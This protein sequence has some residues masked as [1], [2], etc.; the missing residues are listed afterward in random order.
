[1]NIKEYRDKYSK[2][3]ARRSLLSE[4]QQKVQQDIA[5]L[6]SREKAI[7][8]TVSYVQQIAKQTQEQVKFQLEDIVNMA[9][10]AVYASKY[11]FSVLI[12]AK[13][14]GTEA[15]L[16]LLNENGDELDPMDS[17]GGGVCDILSFALRIALL[18]ISKNDRILIMDEPFKYISKDV[19]ES[20]ME[21][22]KRISHDLD[23]QI[24]CV[25]HDA[26]L[27]ECSDRVFQVTQ[28]E[29]VS[30]VQTIR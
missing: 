28:K 14:G 7:E 26:E 19:K 6:S 25:T 12:E 29:G 10:N 2:A 3:F 5:T 13:R 8:E 20:A 24:I 17:T 9:L 27:I 15:K 21:I 30:H 11:R 23:V 18:I 4:Q 22:I 1:V 16:V